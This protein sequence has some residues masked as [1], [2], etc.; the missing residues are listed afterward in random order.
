MN[1]QPVNKNWFE[2][3]HTNKD[4]WN[5]FKVLRQLASTT[6]IV[7]DFGCFS[8]EPFALLWL[9]DA[10]E[11]VV[12]EIK[13]QHIIRRGEEKVEHQET[14][15]DA[16]DGRTVNFIQADMTKRVSELPEKSFD[17]AFCERTLMS[18]DTAI[19]VQDAINEMASVIKPGG[20]LIAIESMPDDMGNP[21]DISYMFERAG[22][23][24]FT[25]VEAPEKTYSY[26]KPH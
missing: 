24:K 5:D 4:Y 26:T 10:S 17:L 19:E 20:I 2:Q 6:E 7:A 22:L 14:I 12:I 13:E 23:I 11:V 25:L 16:F 1:K 8:S 3:L 18:L 9:L 21:R 15:P